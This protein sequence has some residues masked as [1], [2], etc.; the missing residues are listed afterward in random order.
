MSQYNPADVVM[1][2]KLGNWTCRVRA[3]S[4]QQALSRAAWSFGQQNKAKVQEVHR[5]MEQGPFSLFPENANRISTILDAKQEE[6]NRIWL[7][8]A[9]E[10]YSVSEAKKKI[11]HL[12]ADMDRLALLKEGISKGQ[13]VSV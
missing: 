4:I 3:I 7:S 1:I 6:L 13:H 11:A 5:L 8:A 10:G 9:E 12:Q 2:A